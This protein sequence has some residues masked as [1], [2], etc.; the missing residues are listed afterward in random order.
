MRIVIY[1][2]GAIGGV[3]GGRLFEHGTDVVLIARGA[4]YEALRR[5]GLRIETPGGDDVL[6]VPVVDSPAAVDWGDDDVVVL[7]MKTQDTVEA[8]AALEAT[9]A[10]GVPVVC[11]QNGVESERMAARTHDRVYGICVMCPAAHLRPGVVQAFS[12]P[13]PGLFDVGRYPDGS[14]AMAVALAGA[15]RGATFHAEARDDIMRWKYSKLLMNLGN[16]AEALCGPSARVSELARRARREGIA[17]LGAAG[18]AFVSDEDFAARRGD[19]IRPQSIGSGPRPG[20]SSWQSLE[21]RTGRIEADYLNG[22]IALLGRLHGV[23]TPANALLQRAANEAARL[24]RPPGTTSADEL[25]TELT[26]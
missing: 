17:A 16:A 4:H 5:H 26:N 10:V 18:I 8:L 12:V 9:G 22:E 23:A 11:A 20:G 2:A 3:L 14:D 19:L 25:L 24:G 6:A 13:V 15:M 21:R 7:A 1:G